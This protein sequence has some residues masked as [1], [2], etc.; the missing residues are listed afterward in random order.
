MEKEQKL[1]MDRSPNLYNLMK[2]IWP[3]K[4][5]YTPVCKDAARG[6]K[7]GQFQTFNIGKV[8]PN[9]VTQM[10]CKSDLDEPEVLFCPNK[11]IENVK[12]RT[13]KTP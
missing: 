4:N 7:I 12:K 5:T 11:K 1:F 13:L 3:C 8:D 6:F 10:I 9:D 2:E